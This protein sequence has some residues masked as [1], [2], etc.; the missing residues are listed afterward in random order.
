VPLSPCP[1]DSK[2]AG[3]PLSGQLVATGVKDGEREGA[4]ET[5]DIG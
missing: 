1:S 2:F 4:P 5:V 3:V